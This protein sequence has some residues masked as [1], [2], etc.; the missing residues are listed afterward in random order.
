[1][2]VSERGSVQSSLGKAQALVPDRCEQCQHGLQ[3]QCRATAL[4]YIG[5]S[6]VIVVGPAVHTF[7][8]TRATANYGAEHTARG[9]VAG[10]HKGSVCAAK[11]AKKDV[12]HTYL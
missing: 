9:V 11:L 4:Q 3:S 12:S 10:Q 1:M 7:L 2:V 8:I 6:A 5:L